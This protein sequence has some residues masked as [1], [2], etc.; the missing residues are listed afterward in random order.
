MS[1]SHGLTRS[2]GKLTAIVVVIVLV[3][4]F[5]FFFSSKLWMPTSVS[6]TGDVARS[7]EEM[8]Y[9]D[10]RKATFISA[11]FS[12]D[13]KLIEIILQLENTTLD[14]VDAYYYAAKISGGNEEYPEV[15]E[16]FADPLMMVLRIETT[17]FDEIEL[18]FAPKTAAME[19]ISDSETGTLVLN[20]H[21]VTEGKIDNNKTKNE[22]LKERIDIVIASYESKLA[23]Q[24]KQIAELVKEISELTKQNAELKDREKYLT[25]DEVSEAEI[26]ITENINLII[27]KTQNKD[28]LASEAAETEAKIAASQ[29]VESKL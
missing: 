27:Q 20:K 21:N 1:H 8:E 17:K 18:Y 23:R 13:Q 26:L 5:G 11:T 25:P 22:Y 29:D 14:G 10:G 24:N 2:R 16:V 9:A 4:A 19:D 15:K 7:G 28:E 6:I 3:C 12:P